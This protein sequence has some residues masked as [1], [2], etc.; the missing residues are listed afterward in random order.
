[1]QFST[2]ETWNVPVSL[3]SSLPAMPPFACGVFVSVPLDVS[4]TWQW[5]DG[6]WE[7]TL[8]ELSVWSIR[9]NIT[10]GL[11]QIIVW[12][13]MK[14]AGVVCRVSVDSLKVYEDVAGCTEV[15]SV[16]TG[17]FEGIWFIDADTTWI[18]L[19]T[20]RMRLGTRRAVCI[21]G[22]TES[23]FHHRYVICTINPTHE[24]QSYR[25]NT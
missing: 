13:N 6:E 10:V 16:R 23:S 17:R 8:K 12:V 11:A 18:V 14:S 15:R 19:Y 4:E 21:G 2:Y 20:L 3:L 25:K 5:R 22:V 1:M 7:E 9:N 24:V